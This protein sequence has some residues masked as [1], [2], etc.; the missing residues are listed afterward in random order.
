MV[1]PRIDEGQEVGIFLMESAEDGTAMKR[2]GDK[3]SECA[4]SGRAS[5]LSGSQ[6]TKDD[7][8]A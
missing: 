1:K 8:H 2:G 7:V 5:V 3:H 4:E 6:A